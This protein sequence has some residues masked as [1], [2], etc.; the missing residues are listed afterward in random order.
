MRREARPSEHEA[1][2]GLWHTC[3]DLRGSW[4]PCPTGRPQSFGACG[5]HAPIRG[6]RGPRAPGET[7][8]SGQETAT[9]PEKPPGCHATH[10]GPTCASEALARGGG[11]GAEP[12]ND[13]GG[14]ARGELR[15][16]DQGRDLRGRD[17][18]G[19]DLRGRDR[20]GRDGG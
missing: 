18:R 3:P 5:T 15:R 17:R 9:Y 13:R 16:A 19:R 4:P 1:I 10:A 12:G 8:R 14:D 11:P 6:G 7:R 20:W 2:W